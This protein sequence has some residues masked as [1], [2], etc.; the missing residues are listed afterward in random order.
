MTKRKTDIE[1]P[2]TAAQ[3]TEPAETPMTGGNSEAMTGGNTEGIAPARDPLEAVVEEWVSNLVAKTPTVA[4]RRIAAG[5]HA[6]GIHTQDE[7]AHANVNLVRRV[8]VAA[9][10]ADA[11]S[12][13]GTAARFHL[14]D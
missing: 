2:E 3:E 9:L 4:A 13:T 8:L 6:A 11:H 5:L 10:R 7:L 12:L 1:Q 14:E